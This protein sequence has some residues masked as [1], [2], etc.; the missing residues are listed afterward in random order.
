MFI[1]EDSTAA[2]SGTVQV[3]VWWVSDRAWHVAQVQ[4]RL[5]GG[6]LTVHGTG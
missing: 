6:F 5:C 1:L 2:N 3:V 4:I